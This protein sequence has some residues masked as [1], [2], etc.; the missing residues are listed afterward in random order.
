MLELCKLPGFVSRYSVLTISGLPNYCR[1][2]I[3]VD[4]LGFGANSINFNAAYYPIITILNCVVILIDNLK[5]DWSIDVHNNIDDSPDLGL[6]LG[7]FWHVLVNFGLAFGKYDVTCF[8]PFSAQPPKRVS[9]RGLPV[10]KSAKIK[11]G[12]WKCRLK[13]C[14]MWRHGNHVWG[15]YPGGS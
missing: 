14:F 8:R 7:R 4:I 6:L 11:N 9:P 15:Q 2:K 10:W 12:R 1:Q 5:R 13:E 3:A